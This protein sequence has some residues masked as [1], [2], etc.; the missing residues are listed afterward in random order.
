MACV[1]AWAL[2]S[3]SSQAESAG[4]TPDRRPVR[5]IPCFNGS[6]ANQYGL[7]PDWANPD[8]EI[9]VA[10]LEER[11]L[12]GVEEGYTRFVLTLPAGRD[13]NAEYFSSSHWWPQAPERREALGR[14][15]RAWFDAHPET[16]LGVYTGFDLD[17][18]PEDVEFSGHRV[19]QAEDAADVA[20]L[21]DLHLHWFT[22]CGFSEVFF[23]ATSRFVRRNEVTLLVDEFSALGVRVG[24][25][26]MPRLSFYPNRLSESDIETMAWVALVPYFELWDPE[27]AWIADP[28][29]HELFV[30]LTPE[31]IAN[32]ELV[33]D[34][35]SRGF[36]PWVH[37]SG[38]D[39]GLRA[40]ELWFAHR[41]DQIEF[42]E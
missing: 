31:S 17:P 4:F 27:G 15:F 39:I 6:S 24:G 37:G 38:G 1:A 7:Q 21:I 33:Q 29:R 36:I 14:F 26:A 20:A 3:C 30:A 28:G 23:D 42:G 19:P 16:T 25:E 40:R 22:E 41:P 34:I 12:A 10:W 13:F 35:L 11:L 8:V 18:T 9:A 5:A 32:E 2:M